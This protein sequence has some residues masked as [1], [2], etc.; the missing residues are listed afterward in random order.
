M[1]Y[2]K[3]PAREAVERAISWRIEFSAL[4]IQ[5]FSGLDGSRTRQY[6]TT[7]VGRGVLIVVGDCYAPGPEGERWRR[8]PP[9]SRPGGDS[10]AYLRRKEVLDRW[11]QAAWAAGKI[12]REHGDGARKKTKE[13]TPMAY[14]AGEVAVFLGVTQRCVQQKVHRGEIQTISLGGHR[15]IGHAEIIRILEG[16]RKT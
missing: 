14:S 10:P 9:K 3:T 2:I 4:D 1:K 6:L 11:R 7:L 16:R 13:R 5:Q 8:T 15:R 12:E